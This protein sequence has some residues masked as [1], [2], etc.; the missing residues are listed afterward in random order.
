M[1]AD[2]DSK[3]LT[4]KV[5]DTL[6]K[7]VEKN[8]KLAHDYFGILKEQSK[9]KD[10]TTY[11][12]S[13]P[14]AKLDKTFSVEDSKKIVLDALSVLGEDYVAILK[15]A[16]SGGWIDFYETKGKATGGY[17]VS[18]YGVH[19]Y[20]L[21][22]YQPNYRNLSTLA[23][24]LG[25]ACH[26]FY[27]YKNNPISTADE[28]LFVSE[29]AST[30]NE[31]LLLKYMY[32]HAKTKQEKIFYLS[33]FIDDFYATVFVQTM[34]SKFEEYA[35]SVV[36]KDESLSKDLLCDYYGKLVET[37]QGKNVVPQVL[38]KYSWLRIPHFYRCYYVYKY[39]TSYAVATFVANK[40]LNHED[41]MLN[42]YKKFLS[43]G[44]T[45][46]PGNVLKLIG[47]DLENDHVYDIAFQ[48]LKW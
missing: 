20:I 46:Y 36:E 37:F 16:L 24:E 4:T 11:D 10:F 23:H 14:L 30:T 45:D 33:K 17:K 38:S 44:G 29:I 25:H 47:V 42:K 21:L 3:N 39:A 40:I 6:L 19:P 48:E 43:A 32:A 34:Y 41:D 35:H 26:S 31:I 13:M 2:F 18:V 22:N 27:G 9:L 5:Y 1:Q 12:I 15:E 8:L 7:N 28:S